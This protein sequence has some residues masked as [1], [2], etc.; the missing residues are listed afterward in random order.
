MA[1]MSLNVGLKIK[2]FLTEPE[3]WLIICTDLA[4]TSIKKKYINYSKWYSFSVNIYNIW[5]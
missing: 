2:F 5:Q 4:A 3:N 1:G